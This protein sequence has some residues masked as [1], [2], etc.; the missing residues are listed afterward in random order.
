LK[1]RLVDLDEER[2]GVYASYIVDTGGPVAVVDV[3]PAKTVDRLAEEL[4]GKGPIH[5]FITHVHLDHA[6]GLG[7]LVERVQVER[8]YV[9][10][11]GA[12]HLVDPARLWAASVEVLGSTA[13][14]YG[15]PKPVPGRLVYTPK[16]GEEIRLGDATFKV[17]PRR[18]TRATNTPTWRGTCCSPATG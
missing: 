2:P 1:V 7:H 16:P 10:P 6:G 13:L 5:V 14:E 15:K 11:R 18:G 12:P 17:V 9:H 3:G 4:E 8:V